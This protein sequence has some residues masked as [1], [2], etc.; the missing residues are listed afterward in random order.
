MD[1]S[2]Y[3]MEK[4]IYVKDNLF[5]VGCLKIFITHPPPMQ[6]GKSTARLREQDIPVCR[7]PVFRFYLHLQSQLK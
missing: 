2:F 3:P 1:N 4:I 6:A 5:F 7:M